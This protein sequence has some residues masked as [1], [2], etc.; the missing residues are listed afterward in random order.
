MKKLALHW[1]IIIGMVAG[2][3]F[4]L[5]LSNFSWGPTFIQDWIKPFGNIFINALKLIAVPLILASLIKGVSDL[6]DISKLSQMG[7]RTILT[8]VLTTVIAV[9]IG[10][11]AVNL[12]KPGHSITEETRE[13]LIANYD[14]DAELKRKDAQKQKEAGPL[15]ALEDIVPSNIVGAAG[16]NENMLQVIFFASFLVSAL[17]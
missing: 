4:A 9:S 17:F 12:I 14:G 7:L 3:L 1:Q 6:K 10:L 5:V 16:K 15:Q 11:G 2:V 8:Y 13:E